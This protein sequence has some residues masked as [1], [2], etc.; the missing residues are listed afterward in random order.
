[1]VVGIV[2]QAMGQDDLAIALESGLRGVGLDKAVAADHDVTIGVGEVAL[3]RRLG[4][5]WRMLRLAAAAV[6]LGSGSLRVGR[7]FGLGFE[8]GLGGADARQPLLFVAHPIGRLI[9]TPFAAA[10]D[11]LGGIGRRG[12]RQP[13]VDLGR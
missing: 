9:A 4:P 6:S 8:F 11:I 10:G 13:S 5:A 12:V 7:S 2:A 1:M 3:C